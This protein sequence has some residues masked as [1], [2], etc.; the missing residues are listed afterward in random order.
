MVELIKIINVNW[1]ES[2]YDYSF[3][4]QIGN[5]LEFFFSE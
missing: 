4:G 5:L 3:L 2:Y 1:L